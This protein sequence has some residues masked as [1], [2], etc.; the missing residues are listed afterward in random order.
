MCLCA[1][2]RA[3]ASSDGS[4]SIG[5]SGFAIFV[6]V[7][8]IVLSLV[9]LF[10]PVIYGNTAKAARLTRA[11]MEYRV[12]FILIG[13]GTVMSLL[14][15]FIV[16]ISVWTE[17]GC[18]DAT[19]DPH[20]GSRNSGFVSGLPGWCSTKKAAAVFFWFAFAFWA[21]SLTLAFMD[22][23][24]GKSLRPKDPP[25]QHPTDDL[26][27][28]DE[29]GGDEESA[30]QHPVQENR[31]STY[32]DPISN[33]NSSASLP[34]SLPPLSLG[35]S[36]VPQSG[37]FQSS[38]NPRQ[39]MDMYGA[40]SDPPPVGYTAVSGGASSQRPPQPQISKTM[41]YADPYAAIRASISPPTG[42]QAHQPEPSPPSYSFE[43]RY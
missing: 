30:H 37:G 8:G 6:S 5:L 29:E 4:I 20:A 19:K 34:P 28:E 15:A 39:S 31:R 1:C 2:W 3:Y 38:A 42:A 35:S 32:D 36:S 14:I 23:R 26:E 27:Y 7:S 25:F 11:L 41:Q 21:A 24:A 17:P 16:T 33:R 12:Q 13:S 9:L 10:A 18:K 22:W 40:F 43:G